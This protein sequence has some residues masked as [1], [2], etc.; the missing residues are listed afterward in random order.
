[1]TVIRILKDQ[2]MKKIKCAA[3]LL[4][5]MILCSCGSDSSVGKSSESVS[6][7]KD[8]SDSEFFAMDT[9]ITV[10][11]YGEN[12]SDAVKAASEKINSL[13][14][15][16]S[17]TE[18]ESDISKINK[19]GSADVSDDTAYV[20]SE[21]LGFC[22][23]TGGALDIT[24]YPVLLEWGF[25]TDEFRVPT[26]EEISEALAKT[27]YEDVSVSGNN[28]SVPDGYMLDL[29]SCAKGYASDEMIEAMEE[30]GI[31]S[32]IVN[33]GGNVRTLGTKPDGS[34]WSVGIEDPFSP[35]EILGILGVSDKAVITSGGYQRYFTDDEGNVYIHIIDP[36]TGRPANSGLASV[37]VIGDS[38]LMCDALSTS[39]FVMGREKAADYWRKNGGFDMILVTNS[40]TLVM[41]EGIYDKFRNVSG[42]AVEEIIKR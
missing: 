5:V 41:T 37:T 32:A 35:N 15:L 8:F 36:E 2:Y 3:A 11:A 25:T 21:A 12:G 4:S 31:T 30:Y 19:N 9:I 14:K 27:G 7:G 39:L 34:E 38:G 29:G 1:M 40:G 24:M 10:K 6:S 42:M 16:F 20:V 22:E 23:S 17:V 28:I 26:D 13:E 18:E 33:L